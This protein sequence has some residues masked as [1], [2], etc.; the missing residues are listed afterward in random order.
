MKAIGWATWASAYAN[1]GNLRKAIEYSERQLA[2]TRE[3]ED[4]SGEAIACWNL[5]LGYE[6]AGDL[7]RAVDIIQAGV[8]L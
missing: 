5:G 2:I 4:K 8:D 6:K 7:R 1:L 3:I